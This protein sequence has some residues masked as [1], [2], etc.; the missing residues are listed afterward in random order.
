MLMT[1]SLVLFED[2]QVS[3]WWPLAS[4]RPAC[5]Y[6]I[7]LSSLFDKA[8]KLAG[9]VDHVSLLLRPEIADFGRVRYG[10]SH[11]NRLNTSTP[12]WFVNAR[13]VIPQSIW[14]TLVSLPS[15]TRQV[16]VSHGQVVA[17]FFPAAD[18]E[19]AAA[20]LSTI[21]TN[22]AILDRFGPSS[23]FNDGITA[24]SHPWDFLTHNTAILSEELPHQ[25]LGV[26]QGDLGA[27]SSLK[28][29]AYIFVGPGAVVDDFAFLDASD[30]PIY[31][32]ENTYIQAGS[33]LKGPLYIGANTHVLGGNIS[34]SSIGRGCKI[35]GEVS[36]SIV[37]GNSNKAH[38]GYVGDSVIGFWVNLGAMTTT[39]NLKNTYTPVSVTQPDGTRLDTGRQFLGSIIGD[40]TKTAIGTLLNTGTL[41]GMGCNLLGAHLHAGCVPDFSWGE[42]RT[43][44]PYRLDTFFHTLR[45]VYARR[46]IDL[47]DSEIQV[48][49]GR[50]NQKVSL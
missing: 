36:K 29:E 41:V 17:L 43:Y 15:T 33:R 20:F 27:L 50:H 12:T 23:I 6:L 8:V 34:A 47:H 24:I 49:T 37:C 40:H 48:I 32:G 25:P 11:V 18:L 42:A 21:P 39:S 10:A 3:G 28:N 13:A 7:G 22:E 45:A 31:I 35:G 14:H 2:A 38:D 4:T 9:G 46:Q 1:L 19:E 44:S 16:V 26:I 30:G 5:D